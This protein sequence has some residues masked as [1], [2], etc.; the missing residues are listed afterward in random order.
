LVSSDQ[1][2]GITQLASLALDGTCTVGFWI[3]DLILI[4]N[5]N[6]NLFPWNL[7]SIQR[8][9]ANIKCHFVLPKTSTWWIF[10]QS[11]LHLFSPL[12][13]GT[14]GPSLFWGLRDLTIDQISHTQFANSTMPIHPVWMDLLLFTFGLCWVHAI[15]SALLPSWLAQN[16]STK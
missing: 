14:N 16:S 7:N 15:V 4:Q 1:N 8:L 6:A 2:L 9:D 5:N 10:I 3:G 12:L 11:F 13:Q